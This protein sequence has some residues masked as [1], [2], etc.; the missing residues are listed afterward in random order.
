MASAISGVICHRRDIPF[1]SLC[2]EL[3]IGLRTR[4]L[5]LFLL[6]VNG[7]LIKY[8]QEVRM[9]SLLLCLSMFSMWLFARYFV[10]GKSLVPLII[11]NVLLVWTHYFGWFVVIA[12]VGTIILVQRIKWRP[13][14]I[15]L[16]ATIGSFIPWVLG[17]ITAAGQGTGLDQNIGW[18]PRPVLLEI[19]QFKLNL[20]E[21]FYFQASNADPTSIYRVTVPILIIVAS[22]AVAYFLHWKEHEPDEK[23]AVGLWLF[24]QFSRR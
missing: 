7:P 20:I 9:Y 3:K 4:L 22:A 11:V 23:Q 14:L 19:A 24:L 18:L 5:A 1:V 8:A 21:P 12:E 16:A 2:I 17:V 13:V 10:K 15:M 6:A